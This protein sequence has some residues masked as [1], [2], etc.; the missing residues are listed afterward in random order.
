MD[1]YRLLVTGPLVSVIVSYLPHRSDLGHVV[2]FLPLGGHALCPGGWDE[3]MAN[4]L[5]QNFHAVLFSSPSNYR[6]IS[7][8]FSALSLGM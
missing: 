3:E 8:M 2:P 4:L 1:F 6:H 7:S 5:R